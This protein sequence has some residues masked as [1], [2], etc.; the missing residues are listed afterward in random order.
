MKMNMPPGQ[1]G[2]L[3]DPQYVDVVAAV[4]KGNGFPEGTADLAPDALK[5]ITITKAK[6]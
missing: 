3:T 2:S 6:P 1:G 4:L 5:G